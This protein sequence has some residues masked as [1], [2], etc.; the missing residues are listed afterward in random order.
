LSL[1]FDPTES[2]FVVFSP[3]DPNRPARVANQADFPALTPVANVSGP[4]SVVFERQGGGTGEAI[5]FD[6]LSDW[7]QR[8][9]DSI[10][11]YS[12]TATYSKI[13]QIPEALLEPKR[14]LYL[15]LGRVEVMASVSLNEKELGIA[16]KRP[17]RIAIADVA[18]PGAN[19]LVVRV[20][21]LWPNRM[22]GDEHLPPDS[23]R[24]ESGTLKQWPQWMLENKPSPTGRYT[25]ATWRHWTGDAPLIPSGLLG[26]VTLL[27]EE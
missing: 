23:D 26:P 5:N 14:P 24:N 27:R 15:D 1:R 22:I 17:F 3:R 7:S 19:A 20:V 12:G 6:E 13:I 10:R 25:F 2:Y 21:N 11:Y 4:W 8:P 9:E 18:K 16:W